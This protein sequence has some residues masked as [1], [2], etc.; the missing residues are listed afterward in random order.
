ME[1]NY[2]Y[3][4]TQEPIVLSKSI[5]DICLKTSEPSDTIALYTFL[6][7]TAKWQKTNT[8]KANIRFI[9]KALKWGNRRV[10][11]IKKILTAV[12]LIK[13]VKRNSISSIGWYIE[14]KFIWSRET[15][16]KIGDSDTKNERSVN[17]HF[18]K[19][20]S[21][22]EVPIEHTNALNTININALNDGRENKPILQEIQKLKSIIPPDKNWI[23][24]FFKLNNFKS[25]PNKYFNHYQS[26]NW[27]KG[28][29]KITDWQVN[30]EL[31]ESNEKENFQISP[32][33]TTEYKKLKANAV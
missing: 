14:I 22:E 31:W 9:M 32:G 7:Y 33:S 21:N 23:Q 18:L 3:D 20:C 24:A 8:V 19:K 2:Q 15:V 5:I 16:E 28:T 27:K 26:V 29:T 13:T 12:G 30:A 6:Y 1:E 25:D 4:I 11:N 10:S 17:Q